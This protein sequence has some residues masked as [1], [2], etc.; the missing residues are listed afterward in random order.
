[1]RFSEGIINGKFVE[2]IDPGIFDD[3]EEV[4]VF[5]QEEFSRMF[6]SMKDQLNYIDDISLKLDTN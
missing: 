4:I 6:C 1:M 3:C 2:E 5:T